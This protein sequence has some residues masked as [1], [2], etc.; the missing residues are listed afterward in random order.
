[1][2]MSESPKSAQDYLH[3][4]NMNIQM[5]KK[6]PAGRDFSERNI[7]GSLNEFLIGLSQLGEQA[8]VRALLLVAGKARIRYPIPEHAFEGS[9]EQVKR[10]TGE[11]PQL[12]QDGTE[13]EFN[14]NHTFETGDDTIAGMALTLVELLADFEKYEF[15]V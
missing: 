10:Q 5:I 2:I 15:I 1:M 6:Y 14:T 4:L 9:K 3:Q 7:R 12:R 8:Q 11:V 13:K